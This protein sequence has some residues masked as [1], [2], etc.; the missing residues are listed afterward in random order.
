MGRRSWRSRI[1]QQWLA[2]PQ[3]RGERAIGRAIAGLASHPV[4]WRHR[5]ATVA[6]LQMTGVWV[7]DR[8]LDSLRADLE[9]CEDMAA[10]SKRGALAAGYAAAAAE[11]FPV[12]V[13]MAA[14][15]RNDVTGDSFAAYAVSRAGLA[16][17]YE[18][19]WA[20]GVLHLSLA[21]LCADSRR[22]AAARAHA[23]LARLSFH[24]VNDDEGAAEAG[25]TAQRIEAI[26]TEIPPRLG[27]VEPYFHGKYAKHL[28]GS[29][30]AAAI[31]GHLPLAHAM[32]QEGV[33]R[34]VLADALVP[35]LVGAL[36]T[37]AQ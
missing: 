31:F 18:G 29:I 28:P 21:K 32:A 6:G 26:A 14:G 37:C 36:L 1:K 33:R 9:T 25:G 22:L 24:A 5:K 4:L 20:P 3:H 11:A 12:A 35:C 10:Q 15:R 7:G 30:Q 8:Y 27:D 2:S 16:R 23:E 13:H 19:T 17:S 34:Q